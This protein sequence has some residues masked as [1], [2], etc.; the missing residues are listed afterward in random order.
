VQEV[1][2]RE[3]HDGEATICQIERCPWL[4]TRSCP[5][6]FFQKSSS[7]YRQ[8]DSKIISKQQCPSPPP[9]LLLLLPLSFIRL[10]EGTPHTTTS[11]MTS[12]IF[13][14]PTNVVALLWPRSTKRHSDGKML[15]KVLSCSAKLSLGI[16]SEPVL[17]PV[18]GSS[19]V[20]Y[21]GERYFSTVSSILTIPRFL[22]HLCRRASHHYVGHSLLAKAGFHANQLRYCHQGC[23]IWW[24]NRWP[25]WVW[26]S[27]GY[28]WT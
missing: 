6:H 24:N 28:R 7:R 16:T 25:T 23:Y 4:N 18:L 20:S 26:C 2:S 14:I 27:G 1:R 22:R 15:G 8:F 12:P 11:T 9:Q 19:L 3:R 13:K 10:L 5:S 21:W 17:W